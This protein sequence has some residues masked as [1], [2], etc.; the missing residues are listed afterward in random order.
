[1]SGDERG[2]VVLGDAAG[3]CLGWPSPVVIVS[4]GAYG[5]GGFRGDPRSEWELPAWYAPH[6]AAW[7]G[8][9]SNETTLW[10]WGT[11]VGW[12]VMH[13]ELERAGW[14]YQGLNVWDK[15][16]GHV[17]GRCN[18]GTLRG[19]PV[20][21]EVCAHYVREVRVRGETAGRWM[22]DEWRRT[23]LP[24]QEANRAAGVGE[25]AT[26]KYLRE[27]QWYRP[28]VGALEGL[29]G[30]ANE[31][32]AAGGRPYFSLDGERAASGVELDRALR[33]GKF[34]CPVGWT[35]VWRRGALR[36]RGRG[37]HPN[38]K[39]DDLVG[40]L[41]RASS[42][43]GDVVWEPFGGSFSAVRAAWEQGRRAYGAEVEPETYRA[44]VRGLGLLGAP[45]G[46]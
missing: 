43:E 25:A 42:E 13:G 32:G 44:A 20:V 4:D 34:R 21:T 5:I 36:G 19:F 35:N 12:A 6:L 16:M 18:T 17:A 33:G 29:V 11:E 39:P 8:R 45:R 27:D 22:R 23:G 41:V 46:G 24:M 14:R 38:Q 2:E 26:R 10:F 31:R 1:M 30:W 15:G 3:A 7:A 40:A 9:V 37:A 28:P